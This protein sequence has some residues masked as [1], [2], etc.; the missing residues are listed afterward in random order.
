V[1]DLEEEPECSM[2]S[3][4]FQLAAPK[5]QNRMVEIFMAKNEAAS[6]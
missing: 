4:Q 3:E 5:M 2:K 6:G 1:Q